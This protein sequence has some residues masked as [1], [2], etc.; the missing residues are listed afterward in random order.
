MYTKKYKYS[1]KSITPKT[2]LSDLVVKKYHPQLRQMI[3]ELSR[4]AN[5]NGETEWWRVR[6][7]DFINPRTQLNY[8]PLA[9]FISKAAGK[10]CYG[11]KCSIDTFFRYI[12][13]SEHSNLSAKWKSVKVLTYSWIRYE[14]ENKKQ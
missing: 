13:S 4:L 11:L 14:N 1:D 3:D 2:R 12:T 5:F 8:A 10:D 7:I 9:S 6:K